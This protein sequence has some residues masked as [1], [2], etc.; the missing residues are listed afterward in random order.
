MTTS[1]SP[2]TLP[3]VR[4]VS[5]S[6]VRDASV[7]GRRVVVLDDDPTGT[8][9]VRDLPVLTT[10]AVDDI[11]WALQQNTPG[12]F[13]LTNSRSLDPSE[14]AQLN[15]EIVRAS[16]EA[17][18][19]ENVD[20]AFASRSDSTLRGHFP[21]ETDVIGRVVAD[22]GKA[23]DGVLLS[24]AY[25]DVGRYT[26]DGTHVV[27]SADGLIPVADTEFARDATFGYSSSRLR[28]WAV[29]KSQGAISA[30]DVL[31]LG[32]DE[33]R[34]GTTESIASRVAEARNG[35]IVVLDA[36]TDDDLR[37]VSL[38]VV[39]AEKAGS[40]FVYRIGPSF[41]R[42]RVGQEAAQ[43]IDDAT[44]ESLVSR[45]TH[46][47]IVVGSHV[48]LTSRQLAALSDRRELVRVELD[49][50][51]VLDPTRNTAHLDATVADAAAALKDS[52]V[53][54]STSR[55]LVTGADRDASLDIARTVSAA[56][57]HVVNRVVELNRPSYVIAKG[58]IT[59]ADTATKGL[60]IT[61][62]WIRG[63]LLPGIVSLWEPVGGNAAGLPYIVFAGNVG[64]DNSLA[65][66]VDRLEL[67]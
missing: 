13:V 58:G 63:S 42:A 21:L 64:D 14:A 16:L 60:G 12:F 24:P 54:V 3:P 56:L 37:A 20:L 65:D 23:I 57:S 1:F 10:W 66:V 31:E 17:A 28:D 32:I 61:R 30:E 41:V 27:T 59:S 35:Q 38:A 26:I 43:P 6:D 47:L 39:A 7:G 22:A 33:I 18:A 55:T 45:D 49:V 34:S 5:G 8:Q 46:G 15:E 53:V 52:L 4:S 25:I 40:S 36:V 62:S 51:A 11:R 9:T 67:S 19:H 44:L 29:E 50:E 48:G 2:R